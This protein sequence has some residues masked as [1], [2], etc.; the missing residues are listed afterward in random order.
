MNSLGR[1]VGVGVAVGLLTLAATMPVR[2][3][4]GD[5]ALRDRVNQLV[6]RLDAPKM[7]ARQAAE[8]AL[9]KLGP[10]VL[11]LLPE[12]AKAGNAERRQRL[13]RVRA[14]LSETSDATNLGAS[15]VTLQAKGIRLSE[16][17]QKLQAMTGNP[18]SD[19]REAEGGEAG[20]PTLDLEIVDKPF[21]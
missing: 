15:K 8:E 19:L 3:Q 16:V 17:V 2:G 4:S 5:A 12:G 14:K 6:E 20:N 11:P 10:R 7:E 9:G 13:D 1:S 18:I 21:L